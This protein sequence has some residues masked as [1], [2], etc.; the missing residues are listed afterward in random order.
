MIPAGV[1][2]GIT[3]GEGQVEQ[4]MRHLVSAPHM[5]RLPA[6]AGAMA[7]GGG[8]MAAPPQLILNPS[9]SAAARALM[10]LFQESLRNDFRGD[11]TNLNSSRR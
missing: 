4:A 7:G 8:A 1:V 10:R 3:A 5:P 6:M 11:V 2:E 9:G